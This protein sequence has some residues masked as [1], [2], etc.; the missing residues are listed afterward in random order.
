MDIEEK[1]DILDEVLDEIYD[2]I[3]IC[4][5]FTGI[6]PEEECEPGCEYYSICLKVREEIKNCLG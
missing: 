1:Q 2:E 3:S 6:I 5:A 4:A